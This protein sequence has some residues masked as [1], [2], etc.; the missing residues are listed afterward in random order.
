[1][2]DGNAARKLDT[3]PAHTYKKAHIKKR[4]PK[5]N[6]QQR[7]ARTNAV[8]CMLF[9]FAVVT[10]M[11]YRMVALYDLHAQI[12]ERT[13]ELEKITMENDQ[14]ELKIEKLTDTTRVSEYVSANLGMQKI[15][16]RQIVYVHPKNADEMQRVAKKNVSESGIGIIGVLTTAMEYLR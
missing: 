6:K 14:T 16:S 9:V 5:A 10:L 4:A 1:M 2:F 3:P 8:L 15:E 7:R 12:N 11:V 13:E